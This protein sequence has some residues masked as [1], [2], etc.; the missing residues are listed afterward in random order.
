VDSNGTVYATYAT[1]VAP[2]YSGIV[3]IFPDGTKRWILGLDTVPPSPSP[4]R[5]SA[6]SHNRLT[7]RVVS[8]RVVSCVR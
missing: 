4:T 5:C 6:P 2:L 3:A 8:C 7:C 1:S